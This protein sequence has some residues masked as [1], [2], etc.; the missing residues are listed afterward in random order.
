LDLREIGWEGVEWVHLA[1]D[2]DQ[3]RTLMDTAI[4]LRVP[5]KTEHFLKFW[6]TISF[7][8]RFLTNAAS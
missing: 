5:W 1:H 6:M 8:K 7:S 3:W 4:N 2:R